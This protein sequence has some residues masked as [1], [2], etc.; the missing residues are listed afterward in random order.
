MHTFR[1]GKADIDCLVKK[2][3]ALRK[4]GKTHKAI[5]EELKIDRSYVSH[6][7][8]GKYGQV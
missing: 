6:I 4:S 2:V 7:L 1:R 5:A 8:R 3:S